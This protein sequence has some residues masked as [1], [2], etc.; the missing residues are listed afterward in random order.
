MLL[1]QVTDVTVQSYQVS[2]YLG[3]Q[4]DFRIKAPLSTGRNQVT[5]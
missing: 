5:Q 1:T 4:T 2:H 3:Y